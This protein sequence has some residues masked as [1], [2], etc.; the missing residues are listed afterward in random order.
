MTQRVP[1]WLRKPSHK[2]EVVATEKGWVVKE[3]GE[4]LVRVLNLPQRI[5]EYFGSAQTA[6]EQ[7]QADETPTVVNTQPEPEVLPEVEPDVP[8]AEPQPAPVQ[9]PAPTQ[10]VVKERKKPGPKPKVKQA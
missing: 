10:E 4:L 3:T 6:P 5:A 1:N 7:P 2:K 8:T 9:T